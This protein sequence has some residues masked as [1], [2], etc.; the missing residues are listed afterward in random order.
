MAF[1]REEGLN[2]RAGPDQTSTSMAKL[3]FGARVHVVEDES[4]HPGWQKV[5]TATKGVGFLYAP[6]IH[7]PPRDLIEQ[8]P[9][10]TMVRIRSGQTF[11]G[12]VKEQYG[13][14]GNESTADQNI[15][16]FI[17]AI[18]AV[19]KGDAFVVK[20]DWMDDVGN[21]LIS[22]R[23]ASDTLLKAGYDLWIPSFGF[24]AR[25]D[26]GS[27]TVTG[28][29]TRLVKKIEQK[30]KDFRDAVAAAHKY[31]LP[32][33]THHA[34]DAALGL[35]TGLV[36][37]AVD[38]AKILGVSTAV[39]AL[40][41]ALFGGVGAVPGAEIGF[42]VGLLIL[43]AYGLAMLIEAIVSV[44][45][46]LLGQ[47]AS[48]IGQVWNA[49]GDKKKI[50]QAG[51]TL[52]DALGILVSAILVVVAAY[53]MKK[54]GEAL[55]GTRFAKTV[56]E[57]RLAKWFAERQRGSTTRKTVERANTTAGSAE[58]KAS[59]PP[60][61][62]GASAS[63]VGDDF[64]VET[65]PPA[66]EPVVETRRSGTSRPPKP[67]PAANRGRATSEPH[68]GSTA[69]DIAAVHDE[70]TEGTGS[71]RRSPSDPDELNSPR[72]RRTA[73][74]GEVPGAPRK[75]YRPPGATAPPPPSAPPSVRRAWLRKRL[76]QHVD[77]ARARFEVEGYT[78]NQEIDIR[79]NPRAAARHRGS[80]IDAFAKE[81]VMNDPDLAA[82]VTAPDFVPEPDFIDSSL[83]TPGDDWFDATTVTSWQQHLRKY[84]ARY[85]GG[86]LL[87]TGRLTGPPSP[88]AEPN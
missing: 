73:D 42:E 43:E 28:E 21:W 1:V 53:L 33:I 24:A 55:S 60:R 52:A 25:M 62:G 50:D 16:H 63:G 9:G 49:N 56:G 19:N 31:I 64:T 41:G 48:F 44:A 46:S 45:G 34:G 78:R 66:L 82:V 72:E 54:G 65:H 11:W 37:F 6:R 27:G 7:F 69:E 14:R 58:A 57:S 76:Q 17:N 51:Q 5:A 10:L 70:L 22:G 39:G 2:L 38:A 47:L 75:P 87:D 32:S 18:R 36:D 26:V 77:A 23:D 40:I 12:L 83:R 15:N 4:L 85:G 74:E 71:G 68:P 13:I 30:L 79:T 29:V 80:R 3:A 81:S 67:Q 88:T 35:L 59:A 84:Q 8:D 20:T 86:G 61:S